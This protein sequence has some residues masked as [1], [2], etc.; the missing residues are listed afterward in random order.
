[1]AL[2]AA[3]LK[4]K[5]SKLCQSLSTSLEKILFVWWK[6]SWK[7]S[8]LSLYGIFPKDRTVIS[9]DTAVWCWP[10][11][12]I[13]LL[14]FF[15]YYSLLNIFLS[16]KISYSLRYNYLL[17]HQIIQYSDF[18]FIHWRAGLIHPLHPR[19]FWWFSFH[20]LY[21]L[22]LKVFNWNLN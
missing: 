3:Y 12:N 10:F 21:S 18:L 7:V 15:F 9:I 13:L 6:G 5:H 17:C 19:D 4:Q 1:M 8:C 22:S 11:W 16:I 20:L 2:Y 14:T